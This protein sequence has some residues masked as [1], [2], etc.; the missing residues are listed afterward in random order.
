MRAAPHARA[1]GPWASGASSRAPPAPCGLKPR[2][3]GS[4]PRVGPREAPPSPRAHWL[5]GRGLA[6]VAPRPRSAHVGP[7]RGPG[8]RQQ[9]AADPSPV[10]TCMPRPPGSPPA[11]SRGSR[12]FGPGGPRWPLKRKPVPAN[13]GGDCTLASGTRRGAPSARGPGFGGRGLGLA[14]P[15][16]TSLL[17]RC[18][19]PSRSLASSPWA[20]AGQVPGA[21]PGGPE[22]WLPGSCY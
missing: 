1:E 19:F 10:L 4:S 20:G 13:A 8:N 2:R 22:R 7:P 14:R 18:D 17:P 12:G 9:G 6:R 11:G 3:A 21:S 5:P 16:G 15:Q